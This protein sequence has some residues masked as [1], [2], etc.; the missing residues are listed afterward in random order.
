MTRAGCEHGHLWVSKSTE[1]CFFCSENIHTR[2][3]VRNRSCQSACR[4]HVSTV[5][6]THAAS[7]FLQPLCS[8]SLCSC[9]LCS[10]SSSSSRCAGQAVE[11]MRVAEQEAR[12]AYGPG[13]PN[14]SHGQLP[15]KSEPT[16]PH[17]QTHA[18]THTH[19]HTCSGR[20]AHT[21]HQQS[22][23]SDP[24][25]CCTCWQREQCRLARKQQVLLSCSHNR[26]Q[27]FCCPSGRALQVHRH[28]Q[29][30]APPCCCCCAG[31]GRKGRAKGPGRP[32]Y[33]R[34]CHRRHCRRRAAA[35]GAAAAQAAL[36]WTAPPHRMRAPS[37]H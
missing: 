14:A 32:L 5:Q 4:V 26:F 13:W 3:T 29:Q 21:R 22:S 25:V 12:A 16:H 19:T 31:G 24:P 10:C 37:P 8:C 2:G 7:V 27:F 34:S 11:D 17:I 33:H 36:R 23:Q 6:V 28:S 15:N 30:C 1:G 35:G 9:S 18:E 20:H